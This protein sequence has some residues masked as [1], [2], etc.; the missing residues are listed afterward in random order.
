[1]SNS[2]SLL[3]QVKLFDEDF[4]WYPTTNEQ[5]DCVYQ[6]LKSLELRQYSLLD[7]GA[8]NG[9]VL[10]KLTDLGRSDP[11]FDDYSKIVPGKKYA[12]EKS[13]TLIDALP[14]D[15]FL[16]GCDFYEQTLIDKKVDVA[17]SNPPYSEFSVWA[18]K[19]I[20]EA[21]AS[22][23]FLVL[24]K[25]WVLDQNIQ[26]ALRIRKPSI[27]K[28][29][30]GFNILGTF[31]YHNAEDRKARA[32]V[33]VIHIP[34][35]ESNY[36]HSY[37]EED[38]FDVWFN[39]TFSGLVAPKSKVENYERSQK[40]RE[41]LESRLENA[42]VPGVDLAQ[43]LVGFYQGDM[44]SLFNNY[45]AVSELDADIL[46]TLNVDIGSIKEALKQRIASTKDRYWREL[47]EKLRKV[48]DK[49]THASR[50][51]MLDKLTNNTSV[52]FNLGN[53]YAVLSWVFKN[54]NAYFDAQLI[55]VYSR[56]IEQANVVLYKSNKRVFED[57]QW[58][59]HQKPND[60]SHFKLDYR[61]VLEQCGGVAISSWS[62]DL[63]RYRGLSQRAA[64]LIDDLC[65][66]AGNLGFDVTDNHRSYYWEAGKKNELCYTNSKGEVVVLFEA[67]AFKNGNL[68]LRLSGKLAT[69]LNVEFGRLKGWLCSA[70]EA[71]SEL[72]IEDDVALDSFKSNLCLT[73]ENSQALI[74]FIKQ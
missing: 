53:I 9:K 13:K 54:A 14:D 38:P 10:S 56:M 72:D 47:F 59:Y 40:E 64:Y 36:G 28:G 48:T 58:R 60:L 4:E 22:H 45:R 63:E 6:K 1:M 66:V 19:A 21:N 52:D 68:H 62:S 69:K 16:V 44:E 33:D 70:S 34:L 32:K 3:E 31:D 5:I 8:G 67:R 41:K 43:V 18:A 49:L 46:K 35:A 11:A 50:T 20:K 51:A 30:P 23:L 61:I 26:E 12:I 42:L 2:I 55:D 39:E 37:Q 29:K 65:T 73:A 27:G 25:R 24:P 71:A 15:V 74:G 57:F 17:F 7:I